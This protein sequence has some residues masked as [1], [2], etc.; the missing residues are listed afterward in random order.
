VLLLGIVVAACL[1][2]GAS[3]VQADETATEKSRDQAAIPFEEREQ[4]APARDNVTVMTG[5]GF[6]DRPSDA[7]TAFAPEGKVL[8]YNATY[9]EYHDVDPATG[10]DTTVMYV[11]A[12]HVP[13]DR[14]GATT[15]CTV[16]IV[17]RVNLTTDE[18]ERLYRSVAP[19][20]VGDNTH[21]VDRIGPDT[22][23][24][25]DI[26]YDRVF[27]L[28]ETTGLI[29]WEWQAQSDYPIDE[30]GSFPDDW[31]HLND[32]EEL[33]SGEIMVSLRNQDQVVFLNR[34]NG[35]REEMTLG[36]QDDY[37]TLYEQHNPDYIPESRGGPAVLVADSH[38]DRI[39]EYQRQDGKW[40]QSWEWSDAR[41]NWPR[42]AD[43]LPNGHTLITD[44]SGG[45]VLEINRTGSIVWSIDA[46]GIYDA[47]R[48]G[49]DDESTGGWSAAALDSTNDGP[50]GTNTTS[51]GL[52]SRVAD[53]EDVPPSKRVVEGV[54]PTRI[55]GA[56]EFVAP[57]WVTFADIL[58]AMLAVLA[59][60]VWIA[61]ELWWRRHL[62]TV[63]RPI[64]FG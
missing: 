40:V 53:Y 20:R 29:E 63:R 51:L 7:I 34:S 28:N 14:C 12:N 43:R 58:A 8:Y 6:G 17:E 31:T 57:H 41:V 4:V 64:T 44:T 61:A 13:G 5:Q 27:V 1:F 33:P 15:R 9:D 39:V 54:A 37:D 49:T 3:Y 11:A 21:D 23:L 19:R 59:V 30:G 2:I 10:R 26:A 50:G 62:L 18:T 36:S 35:L 47:E 24:V 45:R 25:A 42:D 38:N 52:D 46:K 48:L 16:S 32:V 60:L 55:V 22:L 56:I